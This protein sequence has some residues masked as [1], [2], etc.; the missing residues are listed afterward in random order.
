MVLS[1]DDINM[2]AKEEFGTQPPIE[3]LRQLLVRPHA[4]PMH[5]KALLL[6]LC[7]GHCAASPIPQERQSDNSVFAFRLYSVTGLTLQI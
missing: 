3:L 6:I 4:G 7:S 5:L 2:P 1:V